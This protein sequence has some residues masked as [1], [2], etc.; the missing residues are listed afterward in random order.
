MRRGEEFGVLLLTY[1]RCTSLQEI[2]SI[3]SR[4]GVNRIYINVDGPKSSSYSD[5]NDQKRVVDL[6]RNWKRMHPEKLVRMN[7]RS[8]NLGC[9]ASVLKSI[10]WAFEYESNLIILEDDCVPDPSFFKYC[11]DSLPILKAENNIM[12]SCGSQFAPLVLTL[13]K[14]MLSR[15]AL[16]WGWATTRQKWLT[17]KSHMLENR[18]KRNW[19]IKF[20]EQVYWRAGARRARYGYVDVWDTILVN[21]MIENE[22]LAILPASSLVSN[23]GDDAFATHT[24][25]DSTFL[26]QNIGQ[27]F[28]S[29]ML[30][31]NHFV[32]GWL[33]KNFYKIRYRHLFSTVATQLLDIISVNRKKVTNLR[34]RWI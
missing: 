26:H 4:A 24:H 7:I 22:L 8:Q 1:K 31:E 9:S 6:C 12:L 13:D 20:Y 18:K 32:D 17:L 25:D 14:W 30:E 28:A 21:S 3:C 27:Y 34:S 11:E 33:K 15:Y 23:K 2:L 5:L 29:Q 10:D 16:T 19:K